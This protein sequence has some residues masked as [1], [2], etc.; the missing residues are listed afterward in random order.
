[1]QLELK[2][3]DQNGVL[4]NLVM[5]AQ[6]EVEAESKASAL[7]YSLVSI[8]KSKSIHLSWLNKKP[9]F[10]ILLF[11]QELVA[12]LHAGLSLVVSIE[13]LAEKSSDRAGQQILNNL[14]SRLHEGQTLS[15]SVAAFPDI[16]PALFVAMVKASERTGDLK[17]VL[18]RY[19]VY[20]VQLEHIRTKIVTASIYPVL[21]VLVG[22]LVSLFLLA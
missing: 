13:T 3:L 16:F 10:D 18:Q 17:N 21:L 5:E 8:H 14:L 12:L 4:S 1:M 22:A 20:R 11:S 2:V 19:V 15:N 9:V 6:N 7:G